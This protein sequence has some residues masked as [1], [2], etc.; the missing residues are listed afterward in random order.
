[1][2]KWFTRAIPVLI[3]VG[4]GWWAWKTFFP[5]HEQIIRAK[6]LDL[7]KTACFPPNEPPVKMMANSERIVLSCMTNVEISVDAPG[8][9]KQTFSGRDELLAGILHVRTSISGFGVEFQDIIIT[10]APDKKSAEANLTAKGRVG[11]Q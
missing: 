9:S 5:N 4:I 6:L 8:Y 11:G 1:M 7:A 2:R 10:V 3:V